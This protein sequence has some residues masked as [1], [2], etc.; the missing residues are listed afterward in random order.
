MLLFS[1]VDFDPSLLSPPDLIEAIEDCG[2][3]AQLLQLNE[4]PLQPADNLDHGS[5]NSSPAIATAR[6]AVGGMTCAVCSGAVERALM[7]LPGVVEATVGLVTAQVAR[8]Q[9]AECKLC[10]FAKAAFQGPFRICCSS[11]ACWSRWE[12]SLEWWRR[13]ST[14]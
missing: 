1:Q 9:P 2:F 14:C 13:Q 10:D 3:E 11:V 5:S 12:G 4:P 6:L 7:G 8:V